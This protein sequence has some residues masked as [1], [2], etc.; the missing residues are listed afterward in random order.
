MANNVQTAAESDVLFLSVKP[1]QMAD[2]LAELKRQASMNRHLV[3]SIAAGIRLRRF[4]TVWGRGP[5]WCA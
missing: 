2:V 1:Q 3:I 4:R 5:G